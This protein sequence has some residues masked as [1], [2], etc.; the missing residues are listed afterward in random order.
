MRDV[1]ATPSTRLSDARGFT[2]VELLVVTAILA[3]LAMMAIPLLSGSE[4]Q[5][6]N[7]AAEETANLLRFAMSE[8]RRTNGYVMVDGKSTPGHLKLFYSNTSGNVPPTSG[9]AAIADP[10]T[11]LPVNL[12][13]FANA[14]SAGVTLTPRFRAGGS[15][16]PQ[17]LI[18]PGG[19]SL[20]GFD[21]SSEGP[22]QVNSDVLLSYGSSSVTVAINEVTGLV[23]LP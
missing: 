2:L 8:A 18:G 16:Q 9:T 12:D 21:G 13:V 20:Q 1:R 14:F 6:L 7:A 4:P 23:T 3:V 5:R 10:M 11:K 15:T 17:L 22:L 19:S